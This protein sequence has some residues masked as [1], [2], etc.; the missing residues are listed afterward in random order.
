M[1]GLG[2]A[3]T[4]DAMMV[5]GL[6]SVNLYGLQIIERPARERAV[7]RALQRVPGKLVGCARIFIVNEDAPAII[8][9][10]DEMDDL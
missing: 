3:D 6:G 8:I 4:R 5:N 9:A 10:T 2:G 7:E 1:F